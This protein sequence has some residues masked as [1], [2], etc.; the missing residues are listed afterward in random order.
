MKNVSYVLL[1]LFA[2]CES[3]YAQTGP[4]GT[5][6]VGAGDQSGWEAFLR[7]D[8]QKLTGLLNYCATVLP[9]RAD[10]YDGNIAGNTITFKCN[11][12]D[13]NRTITFTGRIEG[14]EITFAWER[15]VLEGGS[16]NAAMDKRFGSSAAPQFSAKRVPDGELAKAADEVRGR[17]F[18]GAVNL[19]S[20]DARAEGKLFVPQKVSRVRAVLVVVNYGLG[21]ELSVS[22]QWR[23]LS[24]T[25]DSA[26]LGVWFSNIGPSAQPGDLFAIP[27]DGLVEVFPGL[28]QRLAQ[29]SGHPEL[30]D[31]PLLFWG[32]SG[33]GSVAT[34]L[35]NRF[36]QRTLAFVR[37]HSG[38][39]LRGDL[40]V[41]SKIPALFLVGGN[42]PN[43]GDAAET[44]WKSGRA[45]A[46]PWTF[47]IEPDATH[48]DPND[49]L[50]ANDLM[51]PW[52]EAVLRQ[53]LS[54]DGKA[55]RPITDGSAWMGNNK[56]GEIAPYGAFPGSKAEASWLPNEASARGW[57]AVIGLAK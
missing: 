14:N 32:H 55:P 34:A 20:K 30:V 8:G 40:S 48:G 9:Q 29:D 3:T 2:T 7:A 46:A 33:A 6:R 4:T 51:I 24:E 15:R 49:L 36:P 25:V 17:E 19:L 26:L 39:V 37:Y 28:L 18:S 12:P 53:R 57:R 22:E 38:P 44:L 52:I 45:T 21:F 42:D 41:I 23:K 56:T 50:K 27:G 5:W 1:I 35:A 43:G 47:A 16:Y 54:A 13:G 11:S 10:I 31:A